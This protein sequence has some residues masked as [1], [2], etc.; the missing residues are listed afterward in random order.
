MT[1]HYP[2]EDQALAAVKTIIEYIGDDPDRPGLQETPAR[3]LKAW[4][5]SWGSGYHNAGEGL[6]K[7]FPHEDGDFADGA[8]VLVQ[9]IE[10]YSTCEHHLAPFYGMADVA[11]IPRRNGLVGLSKLARIV[12]HYARRLQVQER[13]TNQIADHIKGSISVDCA[14]IMRAS[15]MCMVSRGVQQQASLTVTSALRGV[16]YQDDKCRAEFMALTNR[17]R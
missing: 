3:F 2:S 7:L 4:R 13:L 12:N 9:G 17:S 6:V 16:F 8:M 11:Y 15:H 5:Q 14:V 10:F 1:R